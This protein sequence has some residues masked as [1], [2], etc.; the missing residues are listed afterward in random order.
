MKR[1]DLVYSTVEKLDTGKGVTT[2]EVSEN[3]HIE[4][5]NISKNLN[6]LVKNKKLYKNSTRP[7][8]YFIK[9]PNDI[10]FDNK[11]SLDKISYLFPSL[12]D[13]CKLA[14]TAILYPPN[15]MDSLIIGETGS[16][17]SMFAKL[18][19]EYAV[20]FFNKKDIPFIHFNCSDYSN[21]PQLLSSQLFGVKKGTFTGATED[22]QGLI[23]KANGG[24]LF[25][26]EIHN[27]PSEGQEMLFLFMD[28]GY[29]RRFGEVSKK[30]K[31]SVR[32]ICA[33]NEDINETLL[34][35][36]LR[37]ISIKIKIPSLRERGLEERLTLIETFLKN[38]SINLNKSIYISYNTMLCFLSYDCIYNVGQLKNDIKL[39]VANAYTEYFINNK[40][41]IKINS[42]DLPKEISKSLSLPLTKE[43]SLLE[44]IK[45]D[46]NYFVYNKD[47]KIESHS[48]QNKRLLMLKSYRN[49]L[50]EVNR[51]V[52][53]KTSSA[54][55]FNELLIKYLEYINNY[56]NEYKYK[57]PYATFTEINEK[58]Y[59]FD[60]NIKKFFNIALYENIFNIHLDLIYDRINFI[61][62][63]INK[64]E[65]KLKLLFPEE[66]KL[67]SDYRKIIEDNLNIYLPFSEFIFIILIAIFIKNN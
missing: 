20:S 24:I 11:S 35:T 10:N 48:F 51:L 36:F 26:D 44:K 43:K 57:L 8:K 53:N 7:V 13:A 59:A 61:N 30:I 5:S 50:I 49:L 46:G 6:S 1:I 66:I 39:C 4:R 12:T 17:K 62:I 58:L 25:L 9:N 32:I 65:N 16:G 56:A 14:K 15:G 18:M 40:K 28:T 41:N 60:N 55:E 37:R 22:R 52:I 29:F 64:L 45:P 21:N 34:S 42:P 54:F 33:T 63:D 67:A 27:L 38:E 3:L 23:E 2:N 19:H 47:T 31:S